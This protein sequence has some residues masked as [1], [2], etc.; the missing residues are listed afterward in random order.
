MPSRFDSL[1]LDKSKP[2]FYDHPAFLAAEKKDASLLEAYADY[3]DELAFDAD[4]LSFARARIVASAQFL[5]QRLLADGRKG[6][7]VDMSQVLSR[8]LEQQ[9]VW[10]YMVKGAAAVYPASDTGIHAAF[11]WL[12]DSRASEQSVAPHAW[13]CAPPCNV[14]DLTLG[15]QENAGDED[16]LLRE[17][18]VAEGARRSTPR[19]EEVFDPPIRDAYARQLRRPITMSDLGHIDKALV[20][21]LQRR[22]TWEVELPNVLIRYVG[23]AVT[24]PDQPFERARGWL[25]GGKSGWELWLEFEAALLAAATATDGDSPGRPS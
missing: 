24:A 13:V 5:H 1:Q 8:F 9:G 14:V 6:A 21:K 12:Y 4:Y 17:P 16:R 19:I 15:R 11:H 2:G 25:I 18:I 7:C 20:T 23:V 22:G 3:I 10:N